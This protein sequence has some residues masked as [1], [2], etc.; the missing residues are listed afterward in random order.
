MNSVPS[1]LAYMRLM[2]RKQAIAPIIE[3][4]VGRQC[5]GSTVTS[6]KFFTKREISCFSGRM[7]WM[8]GYTAATP[9][10][11]AS[12][13]AFTATGCGGSPGIP[14]S[15]RTY[16]CPVAPSIVSISFL[17]S[18]I[19]AREMLRI[20]EV[21]SAR[22]TASASTGVCRLATARLLGDGGSQGDSHLGSSRSGLILPDSVRRDRVRPPPAE[23]REPR[24]RRRPHRA[25]CSPRRPCTRTTRFDAPGA[26]R[27]ASA[28]CRMP[29]GADP[30]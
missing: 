12:I 5:S 13:C 27:V 10:F 23:R 18:R 17:I 11:R 19:D 3:P 16:R 30:G 14:I 2:V 1:R 25:V 6:R 7:P 24:S 29:S 20:P 26:P 28:R 4:T 9:R 21:S 22:A 8:S 15:M